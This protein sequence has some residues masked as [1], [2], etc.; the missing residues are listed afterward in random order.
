MTGTE[1]TLRSVRPP[2][3]RSAQLSVDCMRRFMYI[4]LH[5][6]GCMRTCRR[7]AGGGGVLSVLRP[8]QGLARGHSALRRG[9]ATDRA[10]RYPVQ[11]SVALRLL[12]AVRVCD[13]AG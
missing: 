10:P 8:A 13:L 1:A 4:H 9:A 11:P 12:G 6:D 3:K 2:R 5:G 7:V